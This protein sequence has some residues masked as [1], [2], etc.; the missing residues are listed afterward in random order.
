[1][2]RLYSRDYAKAQSRKVPESLTRAIEK[3]LPLQASERVL[4][5]GSG[6]GHLLSQLQDRAPQAFGIDINHF[7]PNTPNAVKADARFIPFADE[8]FDKVVSVHALEHIEDLEQ[9]FREVDRVTKPGGQGFH[10][11][12]AHYITKAEGAIFD[13][14]RMH[15]FNLVKA[16][17]DA[18][19]L[20]VHRLSPGK[21]REF[22]QGTQLEVVGACRFFVSEGMSVSWGI[23]MVKKPRE[24][25]PK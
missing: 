9:V 17:Q 13:A 7:E 8:T 2:E 4:E 22:A 15:R 10:L 6:N 18:H 3:H 11:F 24:V 23:S 16:W 1:M 21:I 19:R 14:L 5:I 12:P 20:H 25:E